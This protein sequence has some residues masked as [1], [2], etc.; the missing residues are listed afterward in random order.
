MVLLE[1]LNNYTVQMVMAGS[2]ILG[3]T[4]GTV[5]AF[6]L[7]RKQSLLGDAI[8]HATLPGVCLAFLLTQS[9]DPLILIIGAGLSGWLGALLIMGITSQTRIKQDSALGL[10][11]S[12][13]FG[14]GLMLLTII[15][16]MPTATKAGLDKFLFGN[17]ATLLR[18]DI[19]SMGVLSAVIF[20]CLLFYW[21]EFKLIVFDPDFARS[22]GLNI[23][24][25]DVML[26]TLM[27]MA[28]VIGL[29][30]VGVILMS[31]MLVAPAAAARQWTDR[32]GVMVVLSAI[33]GGISGMAGALTSS[34]VMKLPTGPTVVIYLSIIVMISLVFAPNR[35]VL[36]DWLRTHQHKRKIRTTHVLKNLLLFSEINTDPYHAH[37]I[38]A[39]EAIGRGP[40]HQ[41][42][43]QLV[44]EGL[45]QE[46]VP[47]Q[48]ALTE[49]GLKAA[50]SI[51]KEF[52]GE[53]YVFASN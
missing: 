53:E 37:D 40:L 45:V 15:Q 13:F 7:L 47:H 11:L 38:A 33:F 28:I 14:L 23:K 36:W 9:K 4:A 44:R 24:F 27:V 26:T 6:A 43:L 42:M 3:V 20:M 19:W 21:K 25:I 31:A 8:S 49:K 52:E 2:L 51:N 16:R 17:A 32:L 30:T 35:G 50:N 46:T 48:W 12:I 34:L 18:E 1:Y 5:G 10:V 22:L 41:T 29:Q 39:L